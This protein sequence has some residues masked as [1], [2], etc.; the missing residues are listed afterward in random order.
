MV[1]PYLWLKKKKRINCLFSPTDISVWV[2]DPDG[3][4]PVDV[5][6]KLY[7]FL[8]QS[9]PCGW[10]QELWHHRPRLYYD[11]SIHPSTHSSFLPGRCRSQKRA[12]PLKKGAWQHDTDSA[13]LIQL[14][15]AELKRHSWRGNLCYLVAFFS[16]HITDT[17]LSPEEVAVTF[18]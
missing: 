16:K 18:Q 14:L 17:S 5:T 3:N 12:L 15:W 9:C 1:S 7:G 4:Q 10:P 11:L 2:T 8:T 6:V 13:P